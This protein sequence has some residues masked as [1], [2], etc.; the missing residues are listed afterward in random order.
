MFPKHPKRKVMLELLSAFVMSLTLISC[1]FEFKRPLDLTPESA[2][3]YFESLSPEDGADFYVDMR[4]RFPF[5]DDLYIDNVVPALDE[6][7][8]TELRR[9]VKK[10]KDT[11]AFDDVSDLYED[12]SN[13][14]LDSIAMELDENAEIFRSAF[15]TDV[16]PI[17]LVEVDSIVY[18][19]FA[20]VISEFSEMVGNSGDLKTDFQLCWINHVDASKYAKHINNYM[21]IYRQSVRQA[22]DEFYRSVTGKPY[23]ADFEQVSYPSIKIT[24]PYE[25]EN[26]VV[27]YGSELLDQAFWDGIVDLSAMLLP[28]VPKVGNALS[29]GVSAAKIGY[30]IYT[31][32]DKA[33]KVTP[34]VEI[35]LMAT[36]H[37]SNEI[38]DTYLDYVNDLADQMV[39][40]EVDALYDAIENE[41]FNYED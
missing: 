12:F 16:L 1:D 25:A 3:D 38:V 9:V 41:I 14:I 24:Y 13:D 18:T 22:E 8:W 34:E 11:P 28:F 32:I 6:V 30:D 4:G 19:D 5:L 15:E 37:I 10:V 17:I 36:E 31:E 39:Y 33:G 40:A 29:D 7:S 35:E 26:K 27:E 23:K 2:M 20:A 21:E